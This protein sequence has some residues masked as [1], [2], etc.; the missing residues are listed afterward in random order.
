MAP[1]FGG[2]PSQ[3][4]WAYRRTEAALIKVLMGPWQ[5]PQFARLHEVE[6]V[7]PKR[8][9]RDRSPAP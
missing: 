3:A 2:P 6:R 7:E 8:Q 4:S 9:A 1:R 5:S